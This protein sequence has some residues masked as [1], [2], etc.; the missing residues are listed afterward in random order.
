MER[1]EAMLAHVAEVREQRVEI[2][3]AEVRV[4]GHLRVAE[5]AGVADEPSRNGAS[6]TMRRCSLMNW[7]A[8]RG[9]R[10]ALT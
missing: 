10:P 6:L 7:N 3:V 9:T 2:G 5:A 1:V 8:G 4:R